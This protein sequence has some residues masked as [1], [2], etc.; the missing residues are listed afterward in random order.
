MKLMLFLFLCHI[1]CLFWYACCCLW[2]VQC[3]VMNFKS[4]YC[5]MLDGKHVK[6]NSNTNCN[7]MLRYDITNWCSSILQDIP[8]CFTTLSS[9]N[10]VSLC[11]MWHSIALKI[12]VEGLWV[13]TLAASVF[14]MERK[15][16]AVHSRETFVCRYQTTWSYPWRPHVLTLTQATL[17]LFPFTKHGWVHSI[18]ASCLGGHGLKSQPGVR[19]HWQVFICFLVSHHTSILIPG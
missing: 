5:C 12:M 2:S 7:R 16:E 11:E 9:S 8:I 18:A 19:L 13:V 15:I 6:M 14:K 4:W 3:I 17:T 10:T 1:Y